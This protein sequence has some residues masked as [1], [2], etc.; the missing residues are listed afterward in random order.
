MGLGKTVQSLAAMAVYEKEWPLLILC[1]SSAR[2]HWEGEVYNWFGKDSMIN[3]HKLLQKK[4]QQQ[5]IEQKIILETEKSSMNPNSEDTNKKEVTNNRCGEDDL[6]ESSK[7][8]DESGDS[9]H[10]F[11]DNGGDG[12]DWHLS[13]S[14]KRR[15]VLNISAQTKYMRLL[16]KHEIHIVSNGKDLWNKSSRVI[17]ISYS[18]A[19]SLIKSKRI[20]PETFN[21]IIVDESHMMKNLKAIR[22]KLILPI[23]KAASRCVLLSGTP[24]FARPIE[25]FPQLNALSCTK[26]DEDNVWDNFEDFVNKY[27]KGSGS[28]GFGGKNLSE[29]H[30]LLVSTGEFNTRV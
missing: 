23:L 18:I 1:P 27:C 8:S 4:A 30:T 25:L 19:I 24:A 5:Q 22:T 26:A 17:I 16:K 21:C 13:N 14:R 3:D 15:K 2:Y 10:T 6:K 11:K 7:D 20:N 9:D 12:K 28:S 29:L